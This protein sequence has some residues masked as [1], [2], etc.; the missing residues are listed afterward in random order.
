MFPIQVPAL[1]DRPEDIPGLVAYFVQKFARQLDRRI[2]RIPADVMD[3][4]ISWSW[5]GNI[6]EL[7][8][9]IERSVI[10]SQGPDLRVPVA[11]LQRPAGTEAA[12]AGRTLEEL[13]RLE[14]MKA[15]RECRGVIGGPAGAAVRLG[16]KRTTLNS[17]MK[18]LGITRGQD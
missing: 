17:R 1:R 11:D 7:Q 10:L 14:I 13:E 15:L 3:R 9:I 2:E 5:P 12:Q 8:N 4:L 6:R 16:L 18:K